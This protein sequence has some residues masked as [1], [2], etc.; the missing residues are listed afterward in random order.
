[1]RSRTFV[2]ISLLLAISKNTFSQSSK[3]LVPAEV[4][5][6]QKGITARFNFTGL[7]DGF[8]QNIS[9][10]GEY[11]FADHWSA[12]S[13]VAYIFA[14]G[15]LGESKS[16]HGLILRPFIRYYPENGR[17]GFFEAGLHYKYVSYKITDWIEKDVV[18]GVPSYQ[19]Y[20]TFHYLKN[21]YEINLKAGTAAN[22]SRNKK[23][24]IEFYGGLGVRF[25]TQKSDNGS[26]S[27]TRGWLGS[28][29]NPRYST[30]VIPIGMR[31]VYDLK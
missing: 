28:L 9:I 2:T 25:K 8:D 26:Y 7:L 20:S 6:L 22:L 1:L 17:Y 23:F 30:L 21:V 12:G 16:S 27:R 15:Y 19:E 13:D 18:N 24:R 14:S 29:Y 5:P 3:G 31:L 4:F 11:R 10:G